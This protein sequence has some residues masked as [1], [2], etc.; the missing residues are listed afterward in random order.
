M[1]TNVHFTRDKRRR[2][3]SM[4][5]F[6]GFI[7]MVLENIPDDIYSKLMSVL[8]EIVEKAENIIYQQLVF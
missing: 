1:F 2:L 5:C 3:R 4:M 6:N 8:E 7:N